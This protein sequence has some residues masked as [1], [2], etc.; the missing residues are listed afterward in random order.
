MLILCHSLNVVFS[1]K[2]KSVMLEIVGSLP[3][4][5]IVGIFTIFL[6]ISIVKRAVRL[7]IWVTAIFVIVVILGIV[8]RFELIN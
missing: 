7:L 6:V 4:L 2:I 1:F 5:I 3:F 8:N